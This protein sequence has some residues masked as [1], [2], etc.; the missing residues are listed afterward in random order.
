MTGKRPEP[1]NRAVTAYME[2]WRPLLNR[3]YWLRYRVWRRVVR[4]NGD[5]GGERFVAWLETGEWQ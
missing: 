4:I 2:L 1:G 3:C 5:A